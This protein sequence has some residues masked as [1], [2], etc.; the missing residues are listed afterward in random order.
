MHALGAVREDGG[1]KEG[2]KLSGHFLR[3][4]AGSIAYVLALHHG[5]SWSPT[6]GIDRARHTMASF[7][8]SYFRG[9]SR[10]LTAAFDALPRNLRVLLR[11]EEASRL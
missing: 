6:L 2:A 10:R 5:A 11:F 1:N 9:V 7:I 4:H 8:R 3:G